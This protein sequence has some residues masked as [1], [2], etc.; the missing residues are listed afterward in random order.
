MAV[1]IEILH[2]LYDMMMILDLYA[3][4]FNSTGWFLVFIMD[5]IKFL[6][7]NRL[8]RVLVPITR[9]RRKTSNQHI[10]TNIL[11]SIVDE[12]RS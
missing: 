10:F 1:Q 2:N 3:T 7:K 9:I 8:P 11:I 6:E 4:Y 5:Y 12:K